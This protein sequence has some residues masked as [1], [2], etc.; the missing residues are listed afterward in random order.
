MLE[1]N[2]E[3]VNQSEAKNADKGKA[4]EDVISLV[5]FFDDNDPTPKWITKASVFTNL[6]SG[7][8]YRF[9]LYQALHPEDKTTKREDVLL[10]T[11]QSQMVNQQYNDLGLIIGTRLIIDNPYRSAEYME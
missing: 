3:A 8:E 2:N 7:T 5:G 9:Q 6:F 11:L 4:E 1:E 10:I